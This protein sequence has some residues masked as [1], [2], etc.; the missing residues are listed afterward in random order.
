MVAIFPCKDIYPWRL[1]REGKTQDATGKVLGWSREKVKNYVSL[2]NIGHE[3]WEVDGTCMEKS[4]PTRGEGGGP[5]D[6]TDVPFTENLLRS[7]LPLTPEQQIELCLAVAGLPSCRAM[8]L[9]CHTQEEIAEA[10]GVDQATVARWL[11]DFMQNS[12]AEES[13]N[14]HNFEPPLYNVWNGGRYSFPARLPP[15]RLF[16]TAPSAVAE[17]CWRKCRSNEE[18]GQ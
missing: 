5:L 11:H 7:I 9:A 3:A 15:W 12:E 2:Q 6:G 16:P 17:S 18:A 1:A 4:V 8:W 10:A 14:W 13:I